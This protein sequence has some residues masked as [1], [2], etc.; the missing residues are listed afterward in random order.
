MFPTLDHFK[1]ANTPKVESPKVGIYQI[2]ADNIKVGSLIELIYSYNIYSD[3][4]LKDIIIEGISRKD[5]IQYEYKIIYP[6]ENI[7]RMK[8][9]FLTINITKIIFSEISTY[10]IH[11]FD[12]NKLKSPEIQFY[13][14][15]HIPK[16]PKIR[17]DKYK[18]IPKC[19]YKFTKEEIYTPISSPSALELLG[20]K[21]V[22]MMQ[23]D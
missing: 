19:I 11:I 20:F 16:K 4:Y 3:E 9:N 23:Y 12:G 15:N 21:S 22:R 6:Y 17:L 8:T 1:M 2:L 7:Y 10:E 13:I 14:L 18:K 5:N